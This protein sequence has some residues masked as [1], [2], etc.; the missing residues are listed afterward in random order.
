MN[1]ILTIT[2]A[3]AVTAAGLVATTAAAQA[4][5]GHQGRCVTYGEFANAQAGMSKRQVH[6]LFDS[7]GK[8]VSTSSYSGLRSEMRTYRAC[9]GVRRFSDVTIDYDDYSHGSHSRGGRMEVHYKDMT[10]MW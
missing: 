7:R 8:R 10:I 5:G 4:E 9:D 2:A 3:G 6:R 1:K